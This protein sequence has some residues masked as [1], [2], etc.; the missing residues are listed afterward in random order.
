MIQRRDKVTDI[1]IQ[2]DGEAQEGLHGGIE[3]MVLVPMDRVSR[4][5][6]ALGERVQ[7]ELPGHSE[8]LEL[9]GEWTGVNSVWIGLRCGSGHPLSIG[10]TRPQVIDVYVDKSTY[11]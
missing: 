4:Y 10:W 2:A 1:G 3:L 7:G 11:W 9:Y 5:S 8:A 6:G